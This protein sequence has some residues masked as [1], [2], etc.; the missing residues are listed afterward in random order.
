MRGSVFLWLFL[1]I[2]ALAASVGFAYR[3]GKLAGRNEQPQLMITNREMMQARKALV[4]QLGA[5]RD[6]VS[7]VAHDSRTHAHTKLQLEKV[8]EKCKT[9]APTS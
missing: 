2:L 9:R 1:S 3:A 6:S 4:G 5:V 8:L 7:E